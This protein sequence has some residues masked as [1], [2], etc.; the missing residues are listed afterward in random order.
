[1]EKEENILYKKYTEENIKNALQDWEYAKNQEPAI[2]S[3]ISKLKLP[4]C[5]VACNSTTTKQTELS[6]NQ[7][8]E[9]C[10]KDDENKCSGCL[11]QIGTSFIVNKKYPIIKFIGLPNHHYI[12]ID[13]KI[14][15]PGYIHVMN[16]F[17][18]IDIDEKNSNIVNGHEV[19]HYCAY[20]TMYNN[21]IKDKE[22]HIIKNNCQ[23]IS[24]FW[25]ETFLILIYHALLILTIITRNVF[26]LLFSIFFMIC[27]IIHSHVIINTKY[28]NVQFC[29]HI[30]KI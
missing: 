2:N 14:W 5:R 20:W 24:G 4:T 6:Y 10:I 18:S 7:H 17:H 25:V 26:L 16:I 3:I 30:K 27:I 11:K 22:F 21:F 15:H 9:T 28:L 12:Q 1:M 13:D 23:L 8:L 29:K 19:C